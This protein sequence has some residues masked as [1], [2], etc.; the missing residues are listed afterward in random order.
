MVL[1]E[2]GLGHHALLTW[3]NGGDEGEG[4][5][6][7]RDGSVADHQAD[8]GSDRRE[9]A[10]HVAHGD[11]RPER[12]RKPAGGDAAGAGAVGREHRGRRARRRLAD[13][14]GCRRAAGSARA[15]AGRRIG[16][17]PGNRPPRAGAWRSPRPDS[18]RPAWSARRCR[19]R[20]GTARPRAAGCRA[21]PT[22]PAAHRH[23]RAAVCASPASF[24]RPGL[25]PLPVNPPRSP[26]SLLLA[27][28][29]WNIS[30]L[31]QPAA[32]S[33]DADAIIAARPRHPASR[34]RL[35]PEARERRDRPRT[36]DANPLVITILGEN[37]TASRAQ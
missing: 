3:R 34:H 1:G 5:D 21:R 25:P 6:L 35:T 2:A 4:G 13:R 7:R 26:P 15:A 30:A 14:A 11:R 20:R 22:R 16:A 28:L 9:I 8:F 24:P 10:A 37:P 29:F 33:H 12:R 19:C 36:H 17:A 31:L 32:A 27:G 23:G 18:P